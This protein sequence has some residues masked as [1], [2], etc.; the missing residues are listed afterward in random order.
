MKLINNIE[1]YKNW[2][3][4]LNILFSLDPKAETRFCSTVE[5]ELW[6]QAFNQT[7]LKQFCD[8]YGIFPE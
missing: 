3:K 6:S 4:F 7:D 8:R 1:K 5:I 2:N